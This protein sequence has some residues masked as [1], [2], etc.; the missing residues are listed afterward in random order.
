MV[1]F[2]ETGV[3][4]EQSGSEARVIALCALLFK[5]LSFLL[6]SVTFKTLRSKITDGCVSTLTKTFL[7]GWGRLTQGMEAGRSHR[8]LL[9][10]LGDRFGSV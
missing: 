5:E 9:W 2:R 4:E 3:T 1:I 8:K 7:L 10:N 6:R